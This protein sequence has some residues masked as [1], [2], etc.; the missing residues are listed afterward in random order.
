MFTDCCSEWQTELEVWQVEEIA[1][2][3][4]FLLPLFLRFLISLFSFSG[5]VSPIRKISRSNVIF[6][7]YGW[8][9]LFWA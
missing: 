3:S 8:F 9:D 5:N 4:I 7:N 2:V 1:E 6:T